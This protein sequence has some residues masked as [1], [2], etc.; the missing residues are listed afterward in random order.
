MREFDVVFMSSG[1]LNAE[2]NWQTL[3]TFY[4]NAKR[5]DGA[6][7]I[8]EAFLCASEISDQD[9][10][11]MVDADNILLSGD[12]ELDS[13]YNEWRIDQVAKNKAVML[14]RASNRVNTLT[15]GHG[16]IKMFSRDSLKKG[17]KGPDVTM[18][19][20]LEI[21]A[22][23]KVA[24]IHA[25]DFDEYNTWKTAFRETAKL[26]YNPLPIARTWIHVW[27]NEGFG[28]FGL[29]SIEGARAGESFA[30]SS[31]EGALTMVNN[32]DW[33]RSEYDRWMKQREIND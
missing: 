11:L 14:W 13:E 8:Y 6:G 26:V 17:F 21:S 15:N 24:S 25:F 3:L 29:Y 18:G 10:I 12:L 30:R 1:E 33:L 20:G 7:S 4:P 32:R 27:C 9:L 16:A 31:S 5:T 22:V 23:M 2:E 19:M 28:P